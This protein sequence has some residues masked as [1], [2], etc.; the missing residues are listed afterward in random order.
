MHKPEKIGDV[1]GGRDALAL[2]PVPE[3]ALEKGRD[4]APMVPPPTPAPAKTPSPPPAEK[5]K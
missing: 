4:G 5:K 3:N 1:S 2:T